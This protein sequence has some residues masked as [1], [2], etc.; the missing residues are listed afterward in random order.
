MTKYRVA[1]DVGGSFTD[2]FFVNEETGEHMV[3]KVPSESDG[4]NAVLKGIQKAGIPVPAIR[5]LTI[6]M[7]VATNAIIERKFPRTAMVTTE[8][9]RDV[10]EIGRGYKDD[11]WDTNYDLA[12]PYV[13]R[14][15][16]LVVPERVAADGSVYTPLD[17]ERARAIARIIKK[18]GIESVAV[19]FINSFKN[20]VHEQAMGLILQ[21][22]LG[23]DALISLSSDVLPEIFEHERFSTTIANACV[24]PVIRTFVR[25]LTS[26]LKQEGLT[27][28]ILIF[29]SGGGVLTAASAERYGARTASSGIA[30]GAIAAARIAGNCGFQNCIGLDMGGTSADISITVDDQIN[31]T[32]DWSIEFGY[33][34][35]FPSL[36]VLTIGAGGG[37]LA[38]IDA[39]GG[40]RNG[41]QSAGSNP[42]PAAYSKGN[43]QATNTDANLVL[44]RLGGELLGG[45]MSLDKSKA[46]T[47]VQTTVA[48]HF[49][50]SATEA[51]QS[52]INIANGNMAQAVRTVSIGRGHDP[53][54]FALVAFGGA[55]PLHGA[56]I[57]RELDIPTVI[58]PPNPGVTS[59][60]GCLLVD[61]RHDLSAMILRRGDELA[62][63]DLMSAFDKLRREGAERL[64]REG[65]DPSHHRFEY[66]SDMRYLGQWRSITVPVDPENISIETVL[67]D[68]HSG[69]EHEY[70]YRREEAPVEI[71][72]INVVAIGMTPPFELAR[73]EPDG[74]EP[75]FRRSRPVVFDG[76]REAIDTPIYQ[77]TDLRA[78]HRLDGPA[79]IEQVDSTVLI[80]PGARG[81]VDRYLNLILAV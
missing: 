60:L 21:E 27:G 62:T 69:H 15:D 43:Q 40:L 37:S 28:D 44:G 58:I 33:P 53:R 52:V 8:G 11:L 35:G 46:E 39:G 55:G 42:G 49:G 45:D 75:E 10:I 18:R 26:D 72:R 23:S 17:T 1:V 68:F 13:A 63:G 32:T 9:F 51:A 70:N 31:S 12:M 3:S 7:T 50:L 61:L 19:C 25:R 79:V 6:G 41:P 2:L 29:H 59:A 80:P 76:Y 30:A 56:A 78:G 54:D 47:A 36:E 14:R 77:R 81:T 38:W 20:P 67:A 65:I 24:S 4:L 74:S 64:E 16:R 66:Y 22:E 73:G 5:M 34:I 57:A 71:F 48:T